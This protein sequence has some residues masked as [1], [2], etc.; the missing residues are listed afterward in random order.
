MSSKKRR[1]KRKIATLVKM[2]QT[3]MRMHWPK[4]YSF[5]RQDAFIGCMSALGKKL[6][7]LG[8]KDRA[9]RA[10]DAAGTDLA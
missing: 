9:A 1:A 3:R 5:E 6:C 8:L 2:D 7:R 4:K 10:L